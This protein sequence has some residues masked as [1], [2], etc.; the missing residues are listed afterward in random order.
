MH[1][2]FSHAARL[3]PG[4]KSLKT[5]TALQSSHK[6]LTAEN[7]RSNIEHEGLWGW[8]RTLL[9]S[10]GCCCV[11]VA[12]DVVTLPDL[13]QCSFSDSSTCPPVA[14]TDDEQSSATCTASTGCT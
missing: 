8:G 10:W 9:D 12:A 4:G 7:I 13:V 3:T 6:S 1:V 5:A 11:F 2:L 14:N